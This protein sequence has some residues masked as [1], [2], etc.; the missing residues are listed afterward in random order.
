M[1]WQKLIKGFPGLL[2]TLGTLLDRSQTI[3]HFFKNSHTMSIGMP[4]R[5]RNYVGKNGPNK[6]WKKRT[7]TYQEQVGKAVPRT[8]WKKT[9]Q[10]VPR[11]SWKRGTK[12]NVGKHVPI[13]MLKQI[14]QDIPRNCWKRRTKFTK[15]KLEKTYQDVPRENWKRRRKTK[16]LLLGLVCITRLCSGILDVLK[17][18]NVYVW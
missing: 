12:K 4:R 14:Y 7:E 1:K 11:Q 5:T 15:N 9:Y 8:S 17:N 3:K 18:K 10:D 6:S 16:P 2:N 13:N